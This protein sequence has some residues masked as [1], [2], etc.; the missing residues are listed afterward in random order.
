MVSNLVGILV[1]S[2]RASE[3]VG[4]GKLLKHSGSIDHADQLVL[5]FLMGLFII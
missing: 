1:M 2:F 3:S 4:L 5:K